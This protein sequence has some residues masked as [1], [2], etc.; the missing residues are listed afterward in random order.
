M[1][2]ISTT[3]F[4]TS[5]L[6][7]TGTSSRSTLQ[8][9]K[10]ETAKR[11]TPTGL[12]RGKFLSWGLVYVT[13]YGV[14]ALKPAKSLSAFRDSGN[15]DTRLLPFPIQIPETS[16]VSKVSLQREIDGRK[17]PLIQRYGSFR[18]F[19]T[20]E[21]E[22]QRLQDS[23]SFKSP[24]S[25]MESRVRDR[26]LL[27]AWIQRSTGF[28]VSGF[29][30]SRRQGFLPFGSPDA[31]TPKRR[32]AAT[33]PFDGRRRPS[34]KIDGRGLFGMINGHDQ[35]PAF[36]NLNHT[37]RHFEASVIGIS[38]LAKTRVLC[39]FVFRVPK[40]R[41]AYQR[42]RVLYRW[43]VQAL[44]WTMGSMVPIP[45]SLAREKEGVV[46]LMPASLS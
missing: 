31:E 38:R 6:S 28:R 14:H 2:R 27:G 10:L 12:A 17:P 3:S 4:R 13:L 15:R 43:T 46:A 20:R 16:E 29:R 25:D 7:A 22:M 42:P 21:F 34:T 44:P 24:N 8:T 11:R 5:R 41:S 9:P 32:P 26:R 23:S 45:S 19:G 37:S 39:P 40:R 33:C 35:I 30:D 18:G 36:L 1:G